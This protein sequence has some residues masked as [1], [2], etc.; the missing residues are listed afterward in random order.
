MTS[1]DAV[2]AAV[3]RLTQDYDL[4]VKHP[5][6]WDRRHTVDLRLLLADRAALVKERDEALQTWPDW[7]REIYDIL[8][9]YGAVEPDESHLPDDLRTWI[10]GCNDEDQRLRSNLLAA[11][12]R[13]EKLAEV[14]KPLAAYADWIDQHH[15]GW[16]HDGFAIAGFEDVWRYSDFARARAALQG[17]EL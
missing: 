5:S 14:L 4:Y 16:A 8:H 17:E 15:A 11:E 1:P 7:A 12:A 2:Q 3:E 6:L 9:E 10:E 13:A